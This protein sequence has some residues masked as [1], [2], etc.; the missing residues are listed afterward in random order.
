MFDSTY[1]PGKAHQEPRIPACRVIRPAPFSITRT[2]SRTTVGGLAYS[3]A[4]T[5]PA[6]AEA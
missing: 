3:G 4:A 5:A 6:P 1:C 2:A